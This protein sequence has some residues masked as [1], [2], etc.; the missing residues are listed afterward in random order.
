MSLECFDQGMFLS[1]SAD[2]IVA[3]FKL[4][5]NEF[6][7]KRVIVFPNYGHYVWLIG[8]LALISAHFDQKKRDSMQY[9]VVFFMFQ[10]NI[11]SCKKTNYFFDCLLYLFLQ[12]RHIAAS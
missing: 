7:Q 4:A 6:T 11:S 8:F 5:N 9:H 12:E 2:F 3:A 1:F 10:F